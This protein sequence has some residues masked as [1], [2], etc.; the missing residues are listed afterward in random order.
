LRKLTTIAVFGYEPPRRTPR[1]SLPAGSRIW[2]AV[3][4]WLNSR[5]SSARHARSKDSASLAHGFR[6]PLGGVAHELVGGSER[7]SAVLGAR[8]A[9]LPD[10]GRHVLHGGK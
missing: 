10:V 9:G 8:D 2:R 4:G 1:N 3:P 5:S 6:R 7:A